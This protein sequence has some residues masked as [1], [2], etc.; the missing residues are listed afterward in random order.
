MY[1]VGIGL[2]FAYLV[3]VTVMGVRA[4]R[5][6]AH[7]PRLPM[8]WGVDGRP[9]WTAPRRAALVVTPLL[10]GSGLFVSTALLLVRPEDAN[11]P[12][13]AIPVLQGGMALVGIGI[14]A[15]FL[16]GVGR[17]PPGE[18]PAAD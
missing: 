15:G 3:A 12:S 9:T 10:A 6:L 18:P 11:V 4:E 1:A 5:L 14:Y 13:A 7:R 2:T 17:T 8:Q 16:W